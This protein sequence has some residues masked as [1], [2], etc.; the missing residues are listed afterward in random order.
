[1]EVEYISLHRYM[2]YKLS[3]TEVGVPGDT[4]WTGVP[5]HQKKNIQ[6]QTKLCRTKELVGETGV[7]VGVVAYGSPAFFLITRIS[8]LIMGTCTLR[9]TQITESKYRRVWKPYAL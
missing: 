6:N 3:G 5:D 7:L 1:M 4:E 8:G 2:R 9:M